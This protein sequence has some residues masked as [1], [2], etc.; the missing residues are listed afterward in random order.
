[1]EVGLHVAVVAEMLGKCAGVDTID[2]GAA[3]FAE[4]LVKGLGGAPVGGFCE[5]VDDEPGKKQSAGLDIFRIYTV[6]ADF[7]AGKH[8]KLS[9][10]ARIGENLLIS[11]HAGVENHLSDCIR[12]GSERNPVEDRAVFERQERLPFPLCP[13]FVD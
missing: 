3:G 11:A 9:R 8:H 7:R 10:I 6:I 12:L 5:V 13:P 4:V 2:A 1:M